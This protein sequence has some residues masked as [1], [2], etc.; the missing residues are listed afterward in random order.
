TPAVRRELREAMERR[1]RGR[2]EE[3][4][5]KSE[6]QL[7]QSQKLEAIGRLAGG[8]AHDFNNH[9]TIIIGYCQLLMDRVG[10]VEAGHNE[11]AIIK[12][13]AVRAASLTRQL[14]AFSRKQVLE[15]RVLDL[16]T[17]LTSLSP[18]L[19]RLIGEDVQLLLSVDPK[20]G[21]VKADQSQ[22]EQ[23]IM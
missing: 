14:L 11:V 10:P 20:L 3:D 6:E 2:A 4:Q 9:L 13:A 8:V 5:R 16:N 21:K 22:I 15:S 17:I 1:A 23:V 18:M 7:R 12:D 19:Q